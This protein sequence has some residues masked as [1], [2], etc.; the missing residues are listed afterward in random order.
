M[1]YFYHQEETHLEKL[2]L[3]NST[4]PMSCLCCSLHVPATL[5]TQALPLTRLQLLLGHIPPSTCPWGASLEMFLP[6]ETVCPLTS[7]MPG[8]TDLE[9]GEDALLPGTPHPSRPL[10][11]RFL[12]Q[13]GFCSR[14][15]PVTGPAV[16]RAGNSGFVTRAGSH[17]SAWLVFLSL[18]SPAAGLNWRRVGFKAPKHLKGRRMGP[19]AQ[20]H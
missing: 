13:I 14:L 16:N 7:S 15:V 12:Q 9:E 10:T 3:I 19:A 20:S 5:P 2:H 11:C 6:G 17:F 1:N 8:L 18:T 4:L